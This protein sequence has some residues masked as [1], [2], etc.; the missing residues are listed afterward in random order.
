M[1][2]QIIE[3]NGKEKGPTNMILVGVHGNEKCGVEAL[4]K[5]LSKKDKY[6]LLM[7]TQKL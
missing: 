5:I 3:L 6:F 4:E 7:V 2:E 1:F